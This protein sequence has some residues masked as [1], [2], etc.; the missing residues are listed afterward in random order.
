[1]TYCCSMRAKFVL[2][3]V[4]ERAD[5]PTPVDVVDFQDFENALP[6]GT[7]VLLIKYCPFCGKTPGKELR[8]TYNPLDL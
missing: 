3:I 5:V 4:G 1:M 2:A 6:D 7:P 8:T